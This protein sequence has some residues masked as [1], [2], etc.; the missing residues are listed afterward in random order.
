MEPYA[1]RALAS[2]A[3]P[4]AFEEAS[5]GEPA[6]VLVRTDEGL[7]DAYLATVAANAEGDFLLVVAE[8]RARPTPTPAGPSGTSAV[9]GGS[10][11]P[12]GKGILLLIP[13]LPVFAA[14]LLADAIAE[15]SKK[16]HRDDAVVDFVGI[17]FS[18]AA[19][20]TVAAIHAHVPGM[21][22]ADARRTF[23]LGLGE[24]LP[25][26]ACGGWKR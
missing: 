16:S 3:C 15:D 20:K 22:E 2:P 14:V 25:G 10:N 24:F 1:A 23:A 4:A 19:G 12:K 8:D 17:L 26:L 13:L 6:A 9:S 5:S 21:N 11:A 18:R 7:D